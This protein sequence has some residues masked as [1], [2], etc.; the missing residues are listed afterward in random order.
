[1]VPNA[2]ALGGLLGLLV[3]LQLQVRVVEERTCGPFGPAY[4]EYAAST[5]RFLPRLGRL[6]DRGVAAPDRS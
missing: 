4:L 3:A 1:M 2:I 5:G 6:S